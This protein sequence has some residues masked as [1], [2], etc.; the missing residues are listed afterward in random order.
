[1]I[2]MCCVIAE[3]SYSLTFEGINAET[4]KETSIEVA[5]LKLL[6]HDSIF[7][8]EFVSMVSEIEERLQ[9][10]FYT[11]VAFLCDYYTFLYCI[12]CLSDYAAL[13]Q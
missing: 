12:S 8:K 3:R 6:L 5:G 11:C 7:A 9:T 4:G 13:K 2:I 10:T 1:M